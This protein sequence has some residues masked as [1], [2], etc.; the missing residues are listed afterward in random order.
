MFDQINTLFLLALAFT[1][2]II[3]CYYHAIEEQEHAYDFKLELYTEHPG[4]ENKL[5]NSGFPSTSV[6]P[7]FFTFEM[8][9]TLLI[10]ICLTYSLFK[11]LKVVLARAQQF[12]QGKEQKE[13]EEISLQDSPQDDLEAS[14]VNE[15]LWEQIKLLRERHQIMGDLLKQVKSSG[16][17]NLQSRASLGPQIPGSGCLALQTRGSLEL[18][19]LFSSTIDSEEHIQTES[20][21]LEV[22]RQSR[23][24]A[25]KPSVFLP[26]SDNCITG[27]MHGP[28]VERSTGTVALPPL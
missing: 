25:L 21:N 8:M 13:Q 5:L 28:L 3:C 23:A 11:V 10:G 9:G 18:Q 16:I 24:Y 26:V 12:W 7:S 22:V 14:S 27:S 17:F 4:F 1:A 19:P 2:W 15:Q 20:V 6:S